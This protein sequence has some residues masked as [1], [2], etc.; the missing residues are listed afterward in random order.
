MFHKL[1][2][3]S[4]I[5]LI[6]LI[7]CGVNIMK[8]VLMIGLLLILAVFVV[9]CGQGTKTTTD[10]TLKNDVQNTQVQTTQKTE[11]NPPV[12]T[13]PTDNSEKS[14]KDFYNYGKLNSFKYQ[15]T[16][17]NKT[18]TMEYTIG[19]DTL[20]GKDTWLQQ[21]KV[22]M[23]GTDVL[24]KTWLDKT[25]LQCLKVSSVVSFNGQEME[26]P[27]QCPTTGPNAASTTAPAVVKE[28]TESITVPAGTYMADKYTSQGATYWVSSQVPVPLRVLT[29]GSD[30]QLMS[31]S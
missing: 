27:G 29:A 8:K 15:F 23:E 21:V 19:S 11:T 20:E 31:Y 30:M 18:T 4:I 3:V 6:Y 10:T 13:Q 24:S 26:T 9:A 1:Y 5:Y 16:V 14:F 7:V 22:N 28:G 17:D 2:K 12:Q 25:T